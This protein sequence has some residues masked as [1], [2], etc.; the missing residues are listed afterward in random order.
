MKQ[1]IFDLVSRDTAVCSALISIVLVL[2]APR[3]AQTIEPIPSI[4][5]LGS[6]NWERGMPSQ[7]LIT[8][9][10]VVGDA[11]RLSA[12]VGA[13]ASLGDMDFLGRDRSTFDWRRDA[14]ADLGTGR[15]IA[16]GRSASLMRRA[17]AAAA[18][19]E[20]EGGMSLDEIARMLDNPLGNLWIIFMENQTTRFRGDPAQGS[21]WVNTF[22]IQPI[23]PIPLTKNWNL[24]TRPIIPLVTA[25]EL[26]LSPPEFGDCPGNCNTPPQ[27]GLPLGNVSASR[28][29]AWGDIM[30]W[31]MISPSEPTVLSD[32]AKFV[33]GLGPAARFPTATEDQFGSERY[34][35]GPSNILMRLPADNGRWTL[36]LFHQH[37]IWSIG[38][39]S[40]RARV[41]TSQIQYIWWYKPP[42]EG[43]WSI[44][45]APMIDVNWEADSGDK[46]SIPVGLGA[47]TTM[48]VGPMPV[49]FGVEFN[50]F[51]RTPDSYGKK[52]LL[53]FYLVPVIPRLVK[54]P[55]FGG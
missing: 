47:S 37:H 33:W 21:K 32:G 24:V 31:T 44:G 53:K 40:D 54:E 7:A 43:E 45:A 36:G 18:A 19:E 28:E 51:V 55:I 30:A 29:T 26:S 17:A 22:M 41:K 23:L 12:G 35:F 8:G 38:G 42:V 50:W 2:A 11:P 6:P 4:P 10:A 52:F 1:S 15:D 49:R 16:W 46:W 3:V 34:S 9:G 48:F 13:A 14:V 5:P 27:S 39:D 20:E 25:P